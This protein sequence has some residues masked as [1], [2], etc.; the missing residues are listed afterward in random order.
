MDFNLGQGDKIDL[1][2]IDADETVNSPF[3]EFSLISLDPFTGI[4]GQLRY[5]FVGNDTRVEG[6]TNGDGL[7]DFEI[8]LTGIIF[9]TFSNFIL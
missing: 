8:N 6:D 3:D 1:A 2:D 5:E 9:L 7:A 4:A